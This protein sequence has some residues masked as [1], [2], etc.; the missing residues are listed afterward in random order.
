MKGPPPAC[1]LAQG[2]GNLRV[3]LLH[4]RDHCRRKMK[5]L[6]RQADGPLYQSLLEQAVRRIN[7]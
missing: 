7:G 6:V 1:S 3:L 4:L 5:A 2:D